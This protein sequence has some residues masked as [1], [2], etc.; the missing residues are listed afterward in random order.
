MEIYYFQPISRASQADI[1]CVVLSGYRKSYCRHFYFTETI[2][3]VFYH[4]EG[5]LRRHY[6]D[7][8]SEYKRINAD[9]AKKMIRAADLGHLVPIVQSAMNFQQKL[10]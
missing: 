3:P 2:A 6:I 8:Y 7:N 9:E 1:V 4:N 10:F 5:Y